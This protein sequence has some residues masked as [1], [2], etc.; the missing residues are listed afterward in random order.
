[1][2]L[3][4][5]FH[6]TMV[7]GL[8]AALLSGCSGAPAMPVPP[9]VLVFSPDAATGPDFVGEGSIDSPGAYQV[10]QLD[11][12]QSYNSVV[13]MTT[14]ATDT[15]VQVETE[16]HVPITTVCE[17]DPWIAAQPCVWGHDNDIDTPNPLRTEQF[18][19]MPASRN[20][21]WEGSL[22]VGTYFIRVT[23]ERGA[24]GT[25]QLAVELNNQDCPDYYCDL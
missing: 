6:M 25:F 1:M 5:T 10:F 13:V 24:T 22:D 20:F 15:A 23:G 16:Q 17:G 11:L 8:G 18:N 21:L 19:S 4:R 12:R 9:T 14:G 7:L 3:I 2:T